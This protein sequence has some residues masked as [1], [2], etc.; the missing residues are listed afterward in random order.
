MPLVKVTNN[1]RNRAL[2]FANQN[3][4]TRIEIRNGTVEHSPDTFN[5]GMETLAK[6]VT[7]MNVGGLAT[8]FQQM[9]L[10]KA[11]TDG[12]KEIADSIGQVNIP[13]SKYTPKEVTN[14]VDQG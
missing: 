8:A 5:I 3:A 4:E 7:G 2:L 13:D 14:I 1:Y 9:N 10:P 11:V 12:F 6:A